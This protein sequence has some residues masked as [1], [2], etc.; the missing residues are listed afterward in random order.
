[1][2]DE[3]RFV[4]YHDDKQG[5]RVEARIEEE[6]IWLTQRQI[7]ELFH[8][9]KS[10]VSEHIKNI[11]E[12]CALTHETAVRKIRTVQQEGSREGTV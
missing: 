3:N 6:T 11:F 7:V 4:I 12:E 10:T 2:S 1:M 9:A 8:T 5:V